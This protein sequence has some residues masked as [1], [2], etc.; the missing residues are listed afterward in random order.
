MFLLLLKNVIQSVMHFSLSNYFLPAV[1]FS[2][3]RS[4]Q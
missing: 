1:A 4:L 2:T 3:L